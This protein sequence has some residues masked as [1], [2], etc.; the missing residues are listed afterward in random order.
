MPKLISKTKKGGMNFNQMVIPQYSPISAR[1]GSK[2]RRTRTR[3]RNM[4]KNKTR[5]NKTRRG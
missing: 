1:G 4:R 3:T 2:Y 5:K